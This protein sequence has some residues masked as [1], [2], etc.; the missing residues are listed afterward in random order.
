MLANRYE[1]V[2]QIF[3]V[4]SVNVLAAG[5]SYSQAGF[6]LD[7]N[8]SRALILALLTREARAVSR[9]GLYV[10]LTVDSDLAFVTILLGEANRLTAASSISYCGQAIFE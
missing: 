1:S 8:F 3:L 9:A 2:L 10:P 5:L 4:R 7:S 6:P